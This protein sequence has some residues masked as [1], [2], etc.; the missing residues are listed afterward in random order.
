MFTYLWPCS[1][2]R[3]GRDLYRAS[4]ANV[5]G[6]DGMGSTPGTAEEECRRA[7]QSYIDE[8]VRDHLN[9]LIALTVQQESEIRGSS[10]NDMVRVEVEFRI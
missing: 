2:T 7:L 4:P 5:E 6:C 8:G 10:G 9:D 3:V 1:I